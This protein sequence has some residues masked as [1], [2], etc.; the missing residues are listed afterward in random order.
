MMKR[1]RGLNTGF[2]NSRS[3]GTDRDKKAG[4]REGIR[5]ACGRKG[6]QEFT[7]AADNGGEIEFIRILSGGRRGRSGK[8]GDS[9]CE[10][11]ENETEPE[12]HDDRGTLFTMESRSANIVFQGIKG[13]FNAPAAGIKV[14]EIGK[15]ESVRKEIGN[16]VFIDT[17]RNFK[18][19]KPQ[20]DGILRAGI[21]KEVKGNIFTDVAIIIGAVWME[22]LFGGLGTGKDTGKGFVQM[23]G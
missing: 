2:A 6:E 22:I 14:G 21:I 9:G 17:F 1:E 19:N 7:T 20:R 15:R 3:A 16:E 13:G 18:T 4:K 11:K 5:R 8:G 23:V 10:V 12:F